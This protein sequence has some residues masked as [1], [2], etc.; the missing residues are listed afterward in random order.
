MGRE[1][2]W[3]WW[4]VSHLLLLLLLLMLM[5]LRVVVCPIQLISRG[6]YG[7]RRRG[8]RGYDG[9][10]R[11]HLLRGHQGRLQLLLGDRGTFTVNL[12]RLCCRC[13]YHALS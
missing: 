12:R 9:G 7:R 4:R 2:N 13:C 11:R 3:W 8:R 6:R 5:L 1:C 10:R